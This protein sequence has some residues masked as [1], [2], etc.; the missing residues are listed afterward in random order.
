MPML[1]ARTTPEHDDFPQERDRY[2]RMSPWL[3]ECLSELRWDL[4]QGMPIPGLRVPDGYLVH[5]HPPH[6]V[7]DSSYSLLLA[8][9]GESHDDDL[10]SVELRQ[11]VRLVGSQ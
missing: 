3:E 8:V 10:E 6:D 2:L 4:Q 9:N 1:A 11:L 7:P 5:L